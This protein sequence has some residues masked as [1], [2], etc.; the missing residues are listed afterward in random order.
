MCV[1]TH[2]GLVW[3]GLVEQPW[4]YSIEILWPP[5]FSTIL[6]LISDFGITGS[7]NIMV[8]QYVRHPLVHWHRLSARG[9]YR[10]C[11]VKV[12]CNSSAHAHKFC[13]WSC[14]VISWSGPRFQG[15]RTLPL[16]DTKLSSSDLLSDWLTHLITFPFLNSH[17]SALYSMCCAA[18]CPAK[19]IEEM[20][21]TFTVH[22]R[23]VQELRQIYP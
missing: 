3:F 18:Y 20:K 15:R 16:I 1:I 5:F 4:I 11:K 10:L 12:L 6:I 7:I 2:H 19:Q 17:W 9:R 21:L 14:S 22:S 8:L 23:T 13:H